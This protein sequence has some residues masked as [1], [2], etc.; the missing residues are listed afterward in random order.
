M[1]SDKRNGM[2]E[3]IGTGMGMWIINRTVAE[4]SGSI[5]L[6]DNTKHTSGFYATINLKKK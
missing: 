6:A 3:P 5:D 2:G 4:Y 1:E